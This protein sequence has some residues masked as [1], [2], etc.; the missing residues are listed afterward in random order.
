MERAASG[1]TERTLFI[2]EDNPPENLVISGGGIKGLAFIGVLKALYDSYGWDFGLKK[3]QI[4]S[5]F[6]VSIGAFVGLLIILGYSIDELMVFARFFDPG[7]IAT[8]NPALFF[9]G[10]SCSFDDGSNLETTIDALIFDRLGVNDVT[11]SQLHEKTG[12][13]FNVIVTNI[14]DCV[15]MTLNSTT[16]PD[17]L[18]KTALLATMAIPPLFP[19]VKLPDGVIVADGGLVDNF[20]IIQ[21]IPVQKT[22]G[23]R[24]TTPPSKST[25]MTPN[26]SFFSYFHRIS[27]LLMNP[28]EETQWYVTPNEYKRRTITIPILSGVGSLDIGS[29][30]NLSVRGSLVTAGIEAGQDAINQWKNGQMPTNSARASKWLQSVAEPLQRYLS[31]KEDE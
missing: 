24:L 13:N 3:P 9:I 2:S 19:P 30:S 5:M 4:S 11:L 23:M 22:L 25:V 31:I 12:V 14:G 20:P 16:Y 7:F 29:V 8:P 15:S 1:A 18:V 27:N 21:S 26:Q 17:L 6:C 28:M 10:N